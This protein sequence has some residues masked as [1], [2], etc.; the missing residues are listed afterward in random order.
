MKLAGQDRILEAEMIDGKNKTFNALRA[1][2]I[3]IACL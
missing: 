3:C 2:M 1:N